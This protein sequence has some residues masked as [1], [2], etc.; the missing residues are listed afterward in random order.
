[1]DDIRHETKS[2]Q[3]LMGVS[4]RKHREIQEIS[5]GKSVDNLE[6]ESHRVWNWL[7][8]MPPINHEQNEYVSR[9]QPLTI[10]ELL[11][12]KDNPYRMEKYTDRTIHFKSR[13]D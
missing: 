10:E 5:A 1:M 6:E 9:Q 11:D 8:T 13:T 2:P 7:P 4:K 12:D 3:E